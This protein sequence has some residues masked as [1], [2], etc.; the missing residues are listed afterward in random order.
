MKPNKG[1][2]RPLCKTCVEWHEPDEFELSAY[3]I[4]DNGHNDANNYV[5]GWCDKCKHYFER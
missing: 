1:A 3:C 4:E 5:N 2:K